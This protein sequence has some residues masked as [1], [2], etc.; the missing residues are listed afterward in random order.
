MQSPFIWI[1]YNSCHCGYRN[2]FSN[3]GGEMTNWKKHF[4]GKRSDL[5]KKGRSNP[6]FPRRGVE[7]KPKEEQ[8]EKKDA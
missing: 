3:K 7:Q 4:Q 5:K 1:N 6:S 2:Y 8:K